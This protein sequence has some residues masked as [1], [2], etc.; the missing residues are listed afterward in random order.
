[1]RLSCSP[2]G[3]CVCINILR[4]V[5]VFTVFLYCALS[6]SRLVILYPWEMNDETPGE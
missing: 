6:F 4:L 2:F 3:L 1:M 5:S